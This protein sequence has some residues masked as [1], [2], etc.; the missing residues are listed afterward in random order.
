MLLLRASN[1][2]NASLTN[3]LKQ[4]ICFI[5]V[6]DMGVQIQ[7]GARDFSRLR[8]VEPGCGAHLVS[9][10]FLTDVLSPRGTN[11]GASG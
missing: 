11:V 6:D 9:Y 3:A 1:E 5:N 7:A 2:L 10:P 8:N 4:I